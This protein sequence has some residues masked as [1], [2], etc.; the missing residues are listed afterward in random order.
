MSQQWAE[1][2]RRIDAWRAAGDPARLRL[3]DLHDEAERYRESHVEHR[4]AL[5]THC[6][7]EA[8]RLDE[9]WWVLFFEFMRL[10]TFTSS[11]HDFA[12]ALPLAM[13]LI[14]RFNSPEGRVHPFR[15]GL[16]IMVLYTYLKIDPLG[17]RD[18]LER[19]F[20]YLDG[21]I[22][23]GPVAERFVLDYRR[24]EYL[25]GVERW[26]EAHELAHRSHALANGCANIW[27]GAWSLFRL[28]R[29]CH[30]L[31]LRDELEG[32]ALFMIELSRKSDGLKRTLADAWLWSAVCR[33]GSGDEQGA[34]NSFHKGMGLLKDLDRREEISADPIAAYY[35]LG[36]DWKAALGVRD[37]ELADVTTRGMLHRSCLV[38]IERCWLLAHQ[39]ELT[40]SDLG[41]VR[42]SAALL[43]HPDWYL[44]K[45]GRV[46]FE[47]KDK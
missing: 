38:Q 8:L 44:G 34:S 26:E 16:L 20:E 19:G 5:M 10:D 17:Y 46:E 7:D 43:R 39:G 22:P 37:R 40:D 29:S 47:V 6:R 15:I 21:E 36:G 2:Y 3:L 41:K 25:S 18:E 30:A 1:F 14:V 32:H 42:E 31:G 45:L 27:H 13:E 4:L 28:C 23:S 11:M 33:R 12:R 24:V 35:E 9:P